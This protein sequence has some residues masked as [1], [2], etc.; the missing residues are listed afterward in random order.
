[1]L[2][3]KD[4]L[5]EVKYLRFIGNSD[6]FINT[7]T[8][9]NILNESDNAL[10]WVNK[11]N[12]DKVFSIKKGTII[13]NDIADENLNEQCNYIVVENPRKTFSEI[14]EKFFVQKKEPYIATSAFVHHSVKLGSSVTIGHN[15]V[16]EENCKIGDNT[17]IG[18][19]TVLYAN[20]IVGNNVKIG[21]NCTI[22]GVGFG[23]EKDDNGEYI[24]IPH[25]GNVVLYD[26]VEIGNNTTIDKAVLGSTT[27]KENSK[28][29]NLVHIAHGVE[30]GKNSLIIANAMIAGSVV[31]GEDVWVAPSVSVLNKLEIANK[32][33]LGM[34]A[35]V[36]KNVK[37]DEVII[38]NPGK[39]LQRNT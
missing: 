29:D 8:N 35:V 20:T 12:L 9:L 19:N 23:Y 26:R 30:I 6:T 25:I 2:K 39:P 28:V 24:L 11:K 22:G 36:L 34:G 38:G 27:L 10:M 15:V 32:S 3:I 7:V 17:V 18:H 1:M 5:Q 16:I 31:I 33:T 13:C 4:I 14:L 37:E 21:S